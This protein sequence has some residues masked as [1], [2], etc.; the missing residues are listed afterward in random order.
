MIEVKAVIGEHEVGLIRITN[1]TKEKDLEYADYS[2]EFGVDTGAGFAVY[3]RSI[4]SFPRKEY[5]VLGLIYQALATLDPKELRLDGDIDDPR[6]PRDAR[7]SG[8]LARQLR[9]AL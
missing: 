3:Q 5:N 9:R 1:L 4:Y 7:L 6:S 8:H 2:I